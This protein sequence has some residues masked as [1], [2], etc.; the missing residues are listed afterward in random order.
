LI[1][2]WTP[3]YGSAF[4]YT[5]LTFAVGCQIT[6]FAVAG[7]PGSNPTY[8]IFNQKKVIS[9]TG[10]TYTQAPA[11]G[12]TFANAFTGTIPSGTA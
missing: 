9:L 1:V 8:T 4:T 3:Q 10:V 11:C 2:T 5:G 6:S 12:Y 7:A